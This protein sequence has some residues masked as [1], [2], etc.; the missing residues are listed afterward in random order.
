MSIQDYIDRLTSKNYNK[1]QKANT[2]QRNRNPD[3]Y[4]AGAVEGDDYISCPVSG[5]RFTSIRKGHITGTLGS[6]EEDFY[7]HFPEI[8]GKV[9]TVLKNNIAAGLKELAYNKDGT[10]YLD[11]TGKHLT[12]HE[13]S[14][15]KSTKTLNEIDPET[16]KRRYDMLGEKTRNT[17][18][19]K[20]DEYGMNGYQQ[21]KMT[22]YLNGNGIKTDSVNKDLWGNYL[23]FI[24]YVTYK[25][26]FSEDITQGQKTTMTRTSYTQHDVQIDHMYSKSSGYKNG[27]SPL[28]IAHTNNCRIVPTIYNLQKGNKSDIT[29]EELFK[30]TDYTN[31]R[32]EYEYHLF[33]NIVEN[34]YKLYDG[35]LT[36]YVIT[37]MID[38]YKDCEYKDIAI[39]Y[40]KDVIT[41][42]Q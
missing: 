36:L 8:K 17:H 28:C 18:M 1:I 12:K 6:T 37:E 16:G 23:E 38:R 15:M 19:N 41:K 35:F 24:A 5:I 39:A 13:V 7:K 31:E 4:K 21:Q 10:P 26:D 22:Q 20:I 11:E 32:S 30:L 34:G 40:L 14:K 25:S 27:I 42:N 33:K 9:A 3:M 29:I 2:R